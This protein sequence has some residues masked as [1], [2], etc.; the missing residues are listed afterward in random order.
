VEDGLDATLIVS[1]LVSAPPA[2]SD[3]VDGLNLQVTPAGTVGQLN[4]N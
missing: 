2:G 4:V 1:V 3:P